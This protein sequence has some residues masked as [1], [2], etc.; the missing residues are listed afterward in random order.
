VSIG[1]VE[2]G[3]SF[4]HL[5]DLCAWL[6]QMCLGYGVDEGWWKLGLEYLHQLQGHPSRDPAHAKAGKTLVS[7]A[8]LALQRQL[9]RVLSHCLL[10]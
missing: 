9:E 8:R 2:P 1:S 7:R 4:A 5:R 6:S 10:A 3:T